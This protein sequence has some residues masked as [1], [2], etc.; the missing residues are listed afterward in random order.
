[1]AIFD[2]PSTLQ[3][4]L[5]TI[6]LRKA[7]LQFASPFNGS[8]QAV[9]FV[10]ERLMLSLTLPPKRRLNA[11]AI[12]ALLF[13]LAGGMDQVRCWHFAR[14]V[15]VG[16]MRGAPTLSATASRGNASVSIQTTAGATLKA[17]DMI[18]A[19]GHL[20]QVREDCVANG[21]GVIVVP[22]VNRVRSTIASGAAVTWDKPTA[23]F[24][25]PSMLNSVAYRPAVLEAAGIDLEE[26]Y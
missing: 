2:W 11:G 6:G 22:L 4:Q 25:C 1:M 8:R 23:L 13:R 16:T 18:G 21:S 3:P 15:P 19:G 17:G 24:V 14:P 10:G 26:W 20:F 9:D 7:G 5:A 12:E